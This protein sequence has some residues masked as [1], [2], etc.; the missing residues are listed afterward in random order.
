M[1]AESIIKGNIYFWKGTET[2]TKIS[3]L[4]HRVIRDIVRTQSQSRVPS[5]RGDDDTEGGVKMCEFHLI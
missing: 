2:E 3:I 4:I 5:I 1:H